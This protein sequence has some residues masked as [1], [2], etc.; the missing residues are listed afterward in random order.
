MRVVFMYELKQNARRK[1][2][3]FTLFGVPVIGLAILFFIMQTTGG[4]PFSGLEDIE[5]DMMEVQVAGYVDQTGAF[6]TPGQ[7]AEDNLRRFDTSEAAREALDAGE[8]DVYFV[9]PPDYFDSAEIEFYAPTFSLVLIT[10]TPMRQLFYSQVLDNGLSMETLSR[11]ATPMSFERIQFSLEEVGENDRPV[12]DEAQQ[13]TLVNISGLLLVFTVFSTN[14]YLMQSVIEEKSSRLIELLIA[15]VRPTQLLAG[16]I[17]ALGVLGLLVVVVYVSALVLGASMATDTGVFLDGLSV[18]THLWFVGIIY[19]LLG[20]LLYS[21]IFGAIGAVSTSL[22]EGSSVLSVFIILIILPYIF[23][24]QFVN[25][26][27]GLMAMGF[28]VFPLTAPIAMI[29]R[30]SITD[31]SILEHV[32]II[33]I[34]SV[35]TLGMLWMAGRLFRVQTLLSGKMPGPREL[36]RLIFG[37]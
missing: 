3:L 15:A 8:I 29:M 25:D 30:A 9:I 13:M 18:P 33:A 24:T 16:K 17:I 14:G 2:F 11:V 19:Y 6:E 26:P 27:N 20:Y 23:T 34:L 22:S 4:E 32:V 7:L 10:R 36:P 21:A 37:G 5:F 31:I 1:G 28:S 12:N 35:S